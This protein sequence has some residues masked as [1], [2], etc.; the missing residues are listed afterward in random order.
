MGTSERTLKDWLK[1]FEPLPN[2]QERLY[3]FHI[4]ERQK[5]AGSVLYRANASRGSLTR[6]EDV[7][8]WKFSACLKEHF[9]VG[10]RYLLS[11]AMELDPSELLSFDSLTPEEKLPFAE[12]EKLAN[13]CEGRIL[14]QVVHRDSLLALVSPGTALQEVETARDGVR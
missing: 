11:D 14:C 4:K 2:N 9:C 1:Y 6:A 3:V 5:I 8:I 13:D 10:E 12:L 7:W